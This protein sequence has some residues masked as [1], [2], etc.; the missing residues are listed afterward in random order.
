M[1]SS[2]SRTRRFLLF[3]ITI[4][5]S[6]SCLADR[7]KQRCRISL[8]IHDEDSISL[9]SFTR[10]QPQP[11]PQYHSAKAT[12]VV[13]LYEVL[14]ISVLSSPNARYSPQWP[15]FL[16][17]DASRASNPPEYE[18]EQKCFTWNRPC[19]LLL[20]LPWLGQPCRHMLLIIYL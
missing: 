10:C 3:Y 20:S 6:K 14:I 13:F 2:F 8:F 17:A 4:V 5:P 7:A 15:P 12:D 19:S 16:S 9:T 1:G 18:H 11:M